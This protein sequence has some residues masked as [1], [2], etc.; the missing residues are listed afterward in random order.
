ML[1]NLLNIF[2]VADLRKKI[3]FSVSQVRSPEATAWLLD[4]AK[5]KSYDVDIRKDAIFSL[6]QGRKIDIEGLQSIYTGARDEPEIQKQVIFVYSQ[7]RESAAVDK[8]MEIAKSDSK[9]EN[10]KEAI[11]WLGQKNDPRVKQFLRDL[12]K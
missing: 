1:D 12:L 5:D 11:F 10:R 2:R 7:T 3:A 8:L 4:V 9:L 6:S